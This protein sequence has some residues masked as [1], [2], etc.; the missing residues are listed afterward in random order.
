MRKI[1]LVYQSGIANVFEVDAMRLNASNRGRTVRLLQGSFRDCAMFARGM[2][3][4]GCYVLTAS[5]NV[6]GDASLVDWQPG[7]EGTPFRDSSNCINVSYAPA[8]RGEVER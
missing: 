4:A 3:A 2:A 6:A 5:C 7:T 8:P 1:M